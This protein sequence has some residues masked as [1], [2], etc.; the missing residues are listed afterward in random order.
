MAEVTPDLNGSWGLFEKNNAFKVSEFSKFTLKGVH[1]YRLANLYN[2]LFTIESINCSKEQQIQR[3]ELSSFLKSEGL[4]ITFL[5][6][7]LNIIASN[8]VSIPIYSSIANR[9]VIGQLGRVYN[10]FNLSYDQREMF[11]DVFSTVLNRLGDDFNCGRVNV[12]YHSS[13]SYIDPFSDN[14]FTGLRIEY[15]SSLTSVIDFQQ[16]IDV[17]QERYLKCIDTIFDKLQLFVQYC[18]YFKFK[19][20]HYYSSLKMNSAKDLCRLTFNAAR[21]ESAQDVSD[22]LSQLMSSIKGQVDQTF[23]SDNRLESISFTCH[24]VMIDD[25]QSVLSSK[26]FLKHQ[27]TPELIRQLKYAVSMEIDIT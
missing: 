21:G 11:I 12:Q 10:E 7:L 16:L 13:T 9:L 17:T 14:H 22:Q 24:D 1:S 23:N 25:L 4:V 8:R 3:D 18:D 27:Q 2:F 20:E 6:S 26:E 19:S 5:R 15:F